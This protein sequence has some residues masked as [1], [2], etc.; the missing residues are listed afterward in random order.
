MERELEF[1]VLGHLEAQAGGRP[2]PLRTAKQ[3]ALLAVLLLQR[4]VVVSTQRLIEALW[5]DEPPETAANTLQVYVSQVRKA[6]AWRP[7]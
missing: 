7:A 4:G 3:R 2:V 1:L 5:G 6:L